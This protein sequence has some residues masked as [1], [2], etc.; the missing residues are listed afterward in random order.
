TNPSVLVDQTKSIEDGLK[1][2]H[3]GLGTNKEYGNAETS[4][5]IELEDLSQFMHDTRSAFLAPDSPTD[6]P[7]IVSDE[8]D[9][10]DK[11]TGTHDASHTKPEDITA[12]HPLSP[13]SVQLQE[14]RNQELPAEFFALPSQIS[15]VQQKLQTLDALPRLLNKVTDTLNRFATLLANVSHKAT[16][17]SVPLAGQT[18]A[19]PAEGEKNTSS[20]TTDANTTNLQNELIDLLGIDV[21]EK[22]HKKKL[23]Y[24]TYCEKMLK[25]R[26]SSKIM[27]YDVLTKK[28]P[29][30]LKVYREDGTN[31]VIPNF[32]VCDLHLVK[33]NEELKIDFN[34]P[35][36]DQ[37]PM[38]ELNDLSKKKRKRTGDLKDHSK[39][40]K[41]HKSSVQHEEELESLK[42]LQLQLFRSL[43]DWE[44]S[45]LQCM[46]RNRN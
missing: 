6:D 1:T 21:V 37:D 16:S 5:K 11:H 25:R 27:N 22:Y 9:V 19:S 2:A 26:K 18:T 43:E 33:W 34:K 17:Q 12:Q 28:G 41:K 8:S 45:S 38:D 10:V 14:L 32:K 36:Q 24:N 31:E 42:V 7:I 29:I 30:I 44:A 13:I 40:T 15:S 39:S 46:Q 3:T 4:T 35:L 20:A 23:L